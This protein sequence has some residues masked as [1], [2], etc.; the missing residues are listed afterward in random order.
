MEN[1]KKK[2]KEDKVEERTATRDFFYIQVITNNMYAI[3][4]IKAKELQVEGIDFLLADKEAPADG[5]RYIFIDRK[6][7][8]TQKRD[9]FLFEPYLQYPGK[10]KEKSWSLGDPDTDNEMYI[11]FID[12][13][14][15]VK[16]ERQLMLEAMKLLLE[17]EPH[18][19]KKKLDTDRKGNPVFKYTVWL[20]KNDKYF[21]M[22]KPIPYDM[23]EECIIFYNMM[24]KKE[25]N[26][27]D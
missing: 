6:T 11:Y 18:R 27:N 14:Q 5:K 26:K 23:T 16:I 15:V 13:L 19:I 3:E 25:E 9:S 22:M 1:N 2:C 20:S 12:E 10:P 7:S 4:Q 24:K 8:E 21:K 17:K